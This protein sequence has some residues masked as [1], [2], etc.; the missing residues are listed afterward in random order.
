VPSPIQAIQANPEVKQLQVEDWEDKAAKEAEL[1]RVQQEI[2]QLHQEEEAITR[3][4]TPTHCAEARRQHIN[5]ERA[6]FA[7]LPYTIEIIRQQ[8]QR[9][10]PPLEQPYHQPIPQPPPPPS[11]MQIPHL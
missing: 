4:Q 6:S 1:A 9:Q 2:V 5:R 3:R 10:E 8:E 11:Q 7:E